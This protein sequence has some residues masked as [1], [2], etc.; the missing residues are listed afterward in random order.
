[1]ARNLSDGIITYRGITARESGSALHKLAIR[2][3]ELEEELRQRRALELR[4]WL[5][6]ARL[7]V[8]VGL[9]GAAAGAGLAL[10]LG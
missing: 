1:M 4:Q 9:A 5:P 3:H 8:V 6:G 2:A 10:W 7:L